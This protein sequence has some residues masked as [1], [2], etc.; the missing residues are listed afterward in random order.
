VMELKSSLS[1]TLKDDVL[2]RLK[3]VRGQ[4]DGIMRMVDEDRYCIDVLRQI[5]AVQAALERI[6]K[7][8]LKNHFEHCYANA[9]RSGDD[10]R[11]HAEIAELLGLTE[12]SR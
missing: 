12:L 11:A 7:I 5:S 9:I 2:K 3:S 6:S 4:V 8:E 10:E 1:P